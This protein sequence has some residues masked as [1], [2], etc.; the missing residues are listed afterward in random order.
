MDTV[1]KRRRKRG[2]LAKVQGEHSKKMH[3]ALL[4]RESLHKRAQRESPSEARS[5]GETHLWRPYEERTTIVR[6]P[7]ICIRE[8]R[9]SR[10]TFQRVSRDAGLEFG[11]YGVR[12]KRK[13]FPDREEIE[14]LETAPTRNQWATRRLQ[15]WRY[16]TNNDKIEEMQDMENVKVILSLDDLFL[17]AHE[18][19]KNKGEGFLPIKLEGEFPIT[20]HV[21]GN[22]WDGRVDKRSAQYV[23]ALQNSVEDLLAE[24]APEASAEEV[25]GVKRKPPARLVV[26]KSLKL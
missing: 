17:Y 25:F 24:F 6:S 19:A 4:R 5:V 10:T 1:R 12:K 26:P 14:L 2:V 9:H 13:K 11:Q 8:G 18:V 15:P 22:S 20:M 21:E 3:I 16:G 23:L 7:A